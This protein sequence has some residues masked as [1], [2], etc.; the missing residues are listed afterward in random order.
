VLLRTVVGYTPTK[1][2]ED[3]VWRQRN[4]GAR[5]SLGGNVTP[6]EPRR[7]GPQGERPH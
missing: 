7:V 1:E 5:V 2:V 3:L 6:L 4:F